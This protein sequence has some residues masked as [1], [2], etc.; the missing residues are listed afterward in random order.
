[1]LTATTG[2]RSREALC[3]CSCAYSNPCDDV[4]VNVRTPTRDAAI[5]YPNIECSLSRFAYSMSSR[6]A[7]RSASRSTITVCGVIG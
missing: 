5:T 4:A 2:T 3:S 6:P 7:T 1:M